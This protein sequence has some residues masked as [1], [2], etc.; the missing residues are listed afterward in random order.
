M[1]KYFMENWEKCKSEEICEKIK[2]VKDILEDEESKK[3]LETRLEVYKTGNISLYS[4]SE[5]LISKPGINMPSNSLAFLIQSLSVRTAARLNFLITPN[6]DGNLE[7][8][9]AMAPSD[10]R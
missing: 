3:A 8:S 2:R 1:I 4:R 5:A 10:G 9:M 7:N 6:I